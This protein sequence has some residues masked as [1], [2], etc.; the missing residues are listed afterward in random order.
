MAATPAT[1]GARRP[2]APL[3]ARIRPHLTG[4]AFALP[5]V[6]LFLV[7]WALPIIASFVL[8]LTDFGI[9]NLR[10]P[11]SAPYTGLDNYSKLIHDELFWKAARN[12]A[13]FVVVGV[14]ATIAVG[15]AVA[16]GLNQAALRLKALFRVGY[17]VPVVTS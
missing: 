2:V 11:L 8:S 13:Y 6:L 16:V 9:A 5:F 15:L 17:Y 7:F 4:W 12:T 3:G 10:D 14:P 1:A